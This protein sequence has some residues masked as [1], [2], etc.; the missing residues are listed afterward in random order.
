MTSYSYPLR[1]S[2]LLNI[3]IKLHHPNAKIPQ[4]MD[5]GSVGYDV[6]LQ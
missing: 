1:G 2:C 3:P 5:E 6:S 4:R